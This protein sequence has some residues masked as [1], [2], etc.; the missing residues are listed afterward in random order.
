MTRFVHRL[1]Q[2]IMLTVVVV[3][4]GCGGGAETSTVTTTVPTEHANEVASTASATRCVAE[5]NEKPIPMDV[6]GRDFVAQ[7][8]L[9]TTDGQAAVVE[10]ATGI[11][12]VAFPEVAGGSSLG[13]AA[14]A[15]SYEKGTWGL[16][17]EINHA[18]APL[19]P[20]EAEAQQDAAD[21]R[22]VVMHELQE[23]VE[24]SPNA[25]L[26]PDGKLALSD[27]SKAPESAEEVPEDGEIAQVELEECTTVSFAPNSDAAAAEV[28]VGGGATCEE[29]E[30]DLRSWA[31]GGYEGDPG[32]FTCGEGTPTTTGMS[33]TY[34]HCEDGEKVLQ[35]ISY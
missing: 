14:F 22:S 26:Q 4:S 8:V 24:F 27:T 31:A 35:F 15:F 17:L 16:Y 6:G 20:A 21:R 2:T 9:S 33:G 32:D 3:I 5:W 19:D 34:M 30:E 28:M 23:L 10:D 29:V 11:C 1:A 25:R 12:V 18:E 7:Q 13:G